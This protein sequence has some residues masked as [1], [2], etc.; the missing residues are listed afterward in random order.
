MMFK[1]VN[2]VKRIGFLPHILSLFTIFC[3]NPTPPPLPRVWH[4]SYCETDLRINIA[5]PAFISWAIVATCKEDL[6]RL[7]FRVHLRSV[8]VRQSSRLFNFFLLFVLRPCRLCY[9][10]GGGGYSH[11]FLNAFTEKRLLCTCSHGW[12]FRLS[13]SSRG[14]EMTCW[15]G[16]HTGPVSVQRVPFCPLSSLSPSPLDMGGGE[17]YGNICLS[18]WLFWEH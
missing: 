12:V 10:P 7:L 8:V 4:C 18:D 3:L 17:E 5:A 1:I 15:A 9:W 13:V 6:M 16:C 14:L 2:L 11:V